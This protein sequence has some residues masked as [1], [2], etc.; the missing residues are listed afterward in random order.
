[1]ATNRPVRIALAVENMEGGGVG[2]MTLNLASGLIARGHQVDLL[3]CSLTG[4]YLNSIPDAVRVI[5]HSARAR[6]MR[7]SRDFRR[8]TPASVRVVHI[9]SRWSWK[10]LTRL[11]MA[12]ALRWPWKDAKL[13]NS[14]MAR[15]FLGI[16][17]YVR[18]ERPRVILASLE[19]STTA[20]LLARQWAGK[21]V[22]V[23]VAVHCSVWDVLQTPARTRRL[24]EMLY[25]KADGIVTVSRD[26]ADELTSKMPIPHD[27][28]TPIYNPIFTP[29]LESLASETPTHPWLQ[30]KGLSVILTAGRLHKVKDHRTLLRA[31]ARLAGRPEMRLVILGEGPERTSLEALVRE[32]GLEGKVDMPGWEPNPFAFMIHARMFVLSSRREGLPSVLIEALACGC[33]VVS[34]DG[35]TGPRVI[36]EDGRWGTL[37]PVGD[38][39]ALAQ[40]MEA[41]LEAP[42]DRDALRRRASFFSV[43]R[44]VEQYEKILLDS[45]SSA[46]GP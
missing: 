10:W 45:A 36:L 18:R 9:R 2:R 40:A 1:M 5:A 41:A 33:P 34:T 32:L 20:A 4:P 27:R 13:L 24:A 37:V 38:D 29:D 44:A 31:F 17:Q 28:I 26:L 14:N 3:L 11:R 46:S 35:P 8:Q 43:E 22:R 12:V 7:Q 6:S 39:A 25:P 16:T 30:K 19:T 23:V 15:A 42:P 21:E